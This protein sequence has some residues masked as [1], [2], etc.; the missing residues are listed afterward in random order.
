MARK[1][2]ISED[3][4]KQAISK[5]GYL[6]E[7][8]VIV[9]FEKH[10]FFGGPN[11]AFE[12][13]DEHKSREIDFIATRFTDFTFGKT[14][15]YFLAY[16]EVKKTRNPLVFFERKPLHREAENVEVFIPVVATKELFPFLRPA[17]KIKKILKLSEIHHQAKHDF[18][19]TQFCEIDID[20]AKATHNDLYE[21]VFVPLLKC[22]DSEISD[23][24]NSTR[25]FRP[26]DPTYFLYLFQ[27]IVI[28]SGPLYSYDVNSDSL[29][30]KDYILYR[31]HYES[32]TVKRT[33]FIDIV[34]RDYLPDYIS[35]KLTETYKAVEISLKEGIDK[36]IGYCIK[37]R[38]WEDRLRGLTK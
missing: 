34:T 11:Y 12:D 24:R 14:G 17:R 2:S 19:S 25:P 1:S 27:P 32:R 6:D 21:T 15:F 35:K 7:Q 10:A 16:G 31:R 18:V 36:I 37:D 26:D 30:K 28:I 22:V 3:K 33:L 5:S 29:T 9:E 20:K 8:K 13:Q 23:L 38:E 4:I